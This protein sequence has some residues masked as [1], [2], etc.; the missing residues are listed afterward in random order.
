MNADT[1]GSPSWQAFFVSFAVLLVLF[2]AARGWRLGLPR[3]IIRLL[4]V[5]A[6]YAAAYFGGG[7]FLPLLRPI[8]QLPDFVISAACGALLAL[9]V[10]SVITSIG[11]IIFKRTAQQNSSVV[12]AIYGSSGALIGIFF[13]A[14]FIWLLLV[15]IRAIGGIADAQLHAQAAEDIAPLPRAQ[16]DMRGVQAMDVSALLETL[17]RIKN[18]VELGPVGDVVKS[19]DVLPTGSYQTIAKLGEVFST[20]ATVERFL[21]YPGARELTLHPR[22][23]ALRLDPKIVT[24]IEE[25]RFLE[26][27][28]NP[29]VIEAINDPELIGALKKFDIQRAIDYATQQNSTE[30]RR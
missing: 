11:T 23:T 16:T 26:L 25:G 30:R 1:S 19:T 6:A 17:A 22:I 10:Y 28:R 7:V 12:R 18:S 2:E 8:V 5:I 4:A 15:G 24:M 9:V 29:R 3:Q 27:V 21:S 20:P 13:G 14:F